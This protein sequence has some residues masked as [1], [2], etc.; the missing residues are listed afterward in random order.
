LPACAT[1]A[2]ASQVSSGGYR[3]FF[4]SFFALEFIRE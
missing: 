3:V 2:R 4:A 1:A